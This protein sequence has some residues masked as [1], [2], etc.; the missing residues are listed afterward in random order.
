M[1]GTL[2]LVGQKGGVLKSEHYFRKSDINKII[3]KWRDIY[4]MKFENYFIHAIP[5]LNNNYA[6]ETEFTENG[7]SL[8]DH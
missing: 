6:T 4:G 5:N 2:K 3:E 7:C 1:P 8:Q